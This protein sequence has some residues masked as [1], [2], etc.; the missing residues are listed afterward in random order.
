MACA[1]CPAHEPN[2]F[3]VRSAFLSSST[4]A[5]SFQHHSSGARERG[6]RLEDFESVGSLG[7][8]R[9]SPEYLWF[10]LVE[11]PRVIPVTT[12]AGQDCMC[13]FQFD[14]VIDG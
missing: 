10:K 4:L 5:S 7:C 2:T 12:V 3:H 13:L 11:L 8:V 6:L 1:L 9:R 14:R